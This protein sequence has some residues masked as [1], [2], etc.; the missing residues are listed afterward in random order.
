M[1]IASVR[2]S[3]RLPLLKAKTPRVR[4]VFPPSAPSLSKCLSARIR[5]RWIHVWQLLSTI[6]PS[7]N[8]G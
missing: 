3:N 4:V 7:R 6:L 5:N 8:R 2:V 1:S